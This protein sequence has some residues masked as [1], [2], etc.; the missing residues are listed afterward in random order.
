MNSN[1]KKC[2][3]TEALAS[4]LEDELLAIPDHELDALLQDLGLEPRDAVARVDE[5]FK[6]A[7]KIDATE[8]LAQ[9]RLDRTRELQELARGETEA[10]LN[11]AEL[12]ALVMQKSAVMNGT[13]LHRDFNASTTE[14][15]RSILR[16]LDALE[17]GKDKD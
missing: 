8:R 4:L 3:P 1:S 17:K 2:S 10:S 6:A 14:D 11:H 9:A 13:L 7:L 12:Y 15:L 16:Q 5:A